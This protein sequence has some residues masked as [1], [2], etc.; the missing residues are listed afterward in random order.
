MWLKGW[1]AETSQS[2]LSKKDFDPGSMGSLMTWLDASEAKY[3]TITEGTFSSP[4]NGNDI[5]RWLDKSGKGHDGIPNTSGTTPTWQS[6]SLNSKPT[7]SFSGTNSNMKI[8]DSETEFDGWSE[9]HVFAVI[10]IN[11]NVNWSRVFGKTTNVSQ[12]GNTAWHYATRR[13]DRDPP[14]Y[15]ASATN[16]SGTNY[17]RQKQNSYTASLKN[18][19]GLFSLSY[20]GA[21]FI[22]RIDGTQID[23]CLLYTSPS[24]RD[25]LL[26][27]MPSSA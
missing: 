20:D 14:L 5:A 1:P 24:P 18:N 10:Q 23:T 3:L 25:G 15:F 27:R 6:S 17:W 16:S 9:L 2:L 12:A 4:S 11:G 21:N 13:G 26:S 8:K 7:V 22:T 19:P